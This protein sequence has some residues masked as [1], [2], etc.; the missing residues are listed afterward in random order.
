MG[1]TIFENFAHFSYNLLLLQILSNFCIIFATCHIGR[2]LLY[3]FPIFL[4]TVRCTSRNF[5]VNSWARI[6]YRY[7]YHIHKI[8]AD[9]RKKHIFNVSYLA[10]QLKKKFSIFSRELLLCPLRWIVLGVLRDALMFHET[11]LGPWVRALIAAHNCL[12][13]NFQYVYFSWYT[14]FEKLEKYL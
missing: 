3:N 14:S 2:Y 5:S 6:M 11:Y 10:N 4:I 12:S 13:W 1:I 9:I 8:C 7:L